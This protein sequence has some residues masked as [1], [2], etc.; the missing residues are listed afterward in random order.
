[1]DLYFG[2][3]IDFSTSFTGNYTGNKPFYHVIDC[4]CMGKFSRGLGFKRD[5]GQNGGPRGAQAAISG[6]H[7]G[8]IFNV[9][10]GLGLSL[11]LSPDK[12][13]AQF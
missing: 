5:N 7:A 9:I 2:T 11:T 3:R 4:S 6:C 12:C 13:D 8:P 10:V 1:M